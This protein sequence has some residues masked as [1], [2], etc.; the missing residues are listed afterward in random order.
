M[1]LYLSA[2]GA[3]LFGRL[4]MAWQ[5]SLHTTSRDVIGLGTHPSFMHTNVNGNDPPQAKASKS[6]PEEPGYS[7]QHAVQRLSNKLQDNTVNQ[8]N[9]DFLGKTN[10]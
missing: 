9:I 10:F 2:R 7:I 8:S 3:S 6:W 4:S 5:R 1:E